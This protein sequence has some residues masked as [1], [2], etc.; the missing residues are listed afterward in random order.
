MKTRQPV[1]KIDNKTINLVRFS[2]KKEE[3]KG[4]SVFLEDNNIRDGYALFPFRTKKDVLGYHCVIKDGDSRK[5][6]AYLYARRAKNGSEYFV[7]K[8][9]DNKNCFLFTN[10]NNITE[11]KKSGY[12][13]YRNET[14]KIY[15]NKKLK[16]KIN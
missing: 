4:L 16:D 5:T 11:N 10:A 7:G 15:E 14:N 3:F 13:S 1:L 9:E 6:V 12:K 2:S 8:T